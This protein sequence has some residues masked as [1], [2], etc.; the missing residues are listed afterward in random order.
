MTREEKIE[1]IVDA[2]LAPYE[3]GDIKGLFEYAVDML[4]YG[5]KG[6][7]DRSDE[8]I[9]ELYERALK[10]KGDDLP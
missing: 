10:E 3:C 4:V 9:D 2:L 7:R 8:E 1:A 6:Y 5:F